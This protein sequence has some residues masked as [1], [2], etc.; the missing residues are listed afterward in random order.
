[1]S[2][3]ALSREQALPFAIRALRETFEAYSPAE[4]ERIRADVARRLRAEAQHHEF[5]ARRS[6]GKRAGSALAQ[7]AWDVYGVRAPDR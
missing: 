2:S 3:N 7:L 5:S 4:Q 6:D 1:M